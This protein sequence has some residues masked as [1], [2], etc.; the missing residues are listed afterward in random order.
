MDPTLSAKISEKLVSHKIDVQGR[1]DC[2]AAQSAPFAR[3]VNRED[4]PRFSDLE[5]DLH[6]AI[7]VASSDNRGTTVPKVGKEFPGCCG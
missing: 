6:S 3:L 4:W 1:V 2:P 7:L 5:F